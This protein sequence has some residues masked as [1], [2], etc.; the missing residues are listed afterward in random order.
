MPEARPSPIAPAQPPPSG[1]LPRI[2]L[3]LP[4]FRRDPGAAL[5]VL[6]ELWRL[7]YDGAFVFDH[8]WPL[9][10]PT[11]PALEGWTLLAAVA[12]R[13]GQLQ[14]AA[15]TRDGGGAG[16]L[17]LGTAV[18]RAGLRAPSLVAHMAAT[19]RSAAGTPLIVGLGAG[20]A[21]SR[22]ENRAFGLPYH[23]TADRLAEVEATALALRRAG[24]A[25]AEVWVGGLSPALR[26]LAGRVAD[27]W[28]AWGVTPEELAAGLAQARQAAERAGRDPAAVQAT[29]GG[30]LL[31]GGDAAE[32]RALLDRWAERREP[33]DVAS[34]VAGDAA[35][36]L[37]R[38]RELGEAGATWCVG[39]LVGGSDQQLAAMRSLLAKAAGFATRV[40]RNA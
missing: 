36:V 14:R 11:R 32:A 21:L 38:L 29:W 7:G 8:L 19:V 12:A 5:A 1:P 39:A 17:R 24:S 6:E 22:P 15:G 26:A 23:H 9:L 37:R 30:Q 3:T 16:G 40:P 28:N 27:A 4:Q 13:H 33:R 35:T 20:D 18:T 34:T 25:T 31:L 2:G 10:Q